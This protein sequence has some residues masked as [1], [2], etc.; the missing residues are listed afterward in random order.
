MENWLNEALQQEDLQILNNTI[1]K[2]LAYHTE[3]L[4]S[5]VVS[6]IKKLLK[7]YR[8]AFQRKYQLPK[9]V[10]IYDKPLYWVFVQMEQVHK[11]TKK[12][13]AL[14]QVLEYCK[15]IM[16]SLNFQNSTKSNFSLEDEIILLKNADRK[17]Q[18]FTLARTTNKT[19]LIFNLPFTCNEQ[20]TFLSKEL[21]KGAYLEAFVMR[22]KQR[23]GVLINFVRML[24]FIYNGFIMDDPFEMPFGF[25]KIINIY[26][27]NGIQMTKEE[28][29]INFIEFFGYALLHD[30]KY[31]NIL[32]EQNQLLGFGLVGFFQNIINYC[33]PEKV[34]EWVEISLE[35]SC[36]CNSNKPYKDCCKKKR[37][38]WGIQEGKIVKTIPLEK[39]VIEVLEHNQQLVADILN[40]KLKPSEKIFRLTTSTD[41]HINTMIKVMREAGIDEAKIYAS[42][43]IELVL[44]EMN[45]QMLPDFEAEN[46][47]KAIQEYNEIIKDENNVLD[48]VR[49]LNLYLKE[50]WSTYLDQANSILTLVLNEVK[51]DYFEIKKFRIMDLFD[52]AAFCSERVRQNSEA[53]Y[54]SLKK[55]HYEVSMAINRMMYEDLLSMDVYFKNDVLFKKHIMTLSKIEQGIYK[56]YEK[57]GKVS[58]KIA[59]NPISGET[60]NY[61]ITLKD[62]SKY[63]NENYRKLYDELFRELSNYTHLNIATTDHYFEKA[64]PFYDLD[65]VNIAGILGLFLVN[66]IIFEFSSLEIGDF[67]H[68]DI[69]YFTDKIKELLILALVGMKEIYPKQSSL[70]DTLIK[71]SE[72]YVYVK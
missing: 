67:V 63:A 9:E 38:R 24:G 62:L 44:T 59:V 46:W 53:L 6:Y 21:K 56:K 45:M 3:E 25:H 29:L 68:R 19:I 69:I 15:N 5:E 51:E 14:K 1:D 55:E 72:D 31:S 57:D 11:N 30:T 26:R 65:P 23:N 50:L 54:D 39:P 2:L 47:K 42:Y 10:C 16:V 12:K 4:Q 33:Y 37:L 49:N 20:Y 22:S 48:H 41:F 58:T 70:Y 28:G 61:S 32:G 43:K 52:F 71:C 8:T 35:E 60:I 17:Y 40:R 34:G 66:Q 64:D 18:I 7:Q 36:P 13:D 27:E